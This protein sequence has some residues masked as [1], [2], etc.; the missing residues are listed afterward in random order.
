VL[1][2]SKSGNSDASAV[3][4]EKN[5]ILEVG[6]ELHK[7]HRHQTADVCVSRWQAAG[8]KFSWLYVAAHEVIPRCIS[9]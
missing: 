5:V 9:V 4:V 2:G 3:S 1:A 8:L 7:A 6:L